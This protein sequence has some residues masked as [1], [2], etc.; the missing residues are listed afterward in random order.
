MFGIEKLKE[1]AL[2]T[3]SF[4]EALDKR[5]ED[6]KMSFLETITLGAK[7]K[8]LP[9]IIRNGP[10]ISQEYMDLDSS[11]KEELVEFIKEELELSNDRV[12]DLIENSLSVLASLSGLANQVSSMRIGGEPGQGP[13]E[14][15]P[16]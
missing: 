14:P 9:S 11:E 16:E 13:T 1:A 4:T 5:L 3:I 6:G 15:D 8:D 12:E 7:L 10:E 2:F